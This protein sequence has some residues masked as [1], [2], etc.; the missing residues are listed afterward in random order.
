MS[1]HTLLLWQKMRIANEKEDRFLKRR[2]RNI[3]KDHAESMQDLHQEKCQVVAELRSHRIRKLRSYIRKMHGE[4]E[5]ETIIN[6]KRIQPNT[7]DEARKLMLERNK[8]FSK[9][10]FDDDVDHRVTISRSR[11]LPEFYH[12]RTSLSRGSI[13]GMARNSSAYSTQF[14]GMVD[15]ISET[16]DTV[17]SVFYHP[18]REFEAVGPD[19][20]RHKK[21]GTLLPPVLTNSRPIRVLDGSGCRSSLEKIPKSE[22]P[23]YVP[24][25]KS[26]RNKNFDQFTDG[27]M[28]LEMR[29]SR[30][31]QRERMPPLS[32]HLPVR[33]RYG[34]TYDIEERIEKIQEKLSDVDPGNTE[35]LTKQVMFGVLDPSK[36]KHYKP[37]MTE[38]DD[39]V[40]IEEDNK[41]LN[42]LKKASQMVQYKEALTR[43]D[44][45]IGTT[46]KGSNLVHEETLSREEDL[47]LK[48]LTNEAIFLPK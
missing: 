30:Q 39:S 5:P 34:Q 36:A 20:P 40:G 11:T 6:I 32:G 2:V 41:K 19:S 31:I 27:T 22:T 10:S 9:V 45:F 33:A 21:Y 35:L 44:T 13:G 26:M 15:D 14:P 18:E 1:G 12:P 46:S 7:R 24:Q 16:N 48:T 3:I 29:R 38:V 25:L 8:G 42:K 17:F 37:K 43:V 23:S 28:A 4:E 47:M